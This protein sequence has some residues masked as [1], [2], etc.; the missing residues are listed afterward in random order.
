MSLGDF[1]NYLTEVGLQTLVSELPVAAQYS[2]MRYIQGEMLFFGIASA[3]SA[4]VL[5]LRL[6]VSIFRM[7]NHG[8]V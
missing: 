8:T 7:Y 4:I 5:P 3:V 6:F 1:T 2:V